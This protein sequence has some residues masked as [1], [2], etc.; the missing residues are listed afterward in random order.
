MNKRKN[1][2]K[3][4]PKLN[5]RSLAM[6]GLIMYFGF[7]LIGQQSALHASDAEITQLEEKIAVAESQYAEVEE[8]ETISQ[9]DAY[10][11]KVAREKLGLVLPDEIVFVDVTGQ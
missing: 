4:L 9:S 1:Q 6:I 8:M 3:K 2:S 7:A 5:I 10:I 11:E